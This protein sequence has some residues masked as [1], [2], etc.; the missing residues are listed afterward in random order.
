MLVIVCIPCLVLLYNSDMNVFLFRNIIVSIAVF[1]CVL[2][3]VVVGSV[4]AVVVVGSVLAVVVVSCGG[5]QCVGSCGGWQCVVSCAVGQCCQLWWLLVVIAVIDYPIVFTVNLFI[6]F[7]VLQN[8]EMFMICFQVLIQILNLV[9]FTAYIY[10]YV[11]N[12]SQSKRI[13]K[14]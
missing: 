14:I 3:V 1:V 13:V 4:L 5:W 2:S 6:L 8:Q 9:V 7:C 11:C 10:I 12:F